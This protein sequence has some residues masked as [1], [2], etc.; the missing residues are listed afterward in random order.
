MPGYQTHTTPW[1]VPGFEVGTSDGGTIDLCLNPDAADAGACPAAYVC[2]GGDLPGGG[3]DGCDGL[4]ACCTELC[5][6][7]DGVP[8]CTN[9]AHECI[10]LFF[11]DPGPPDQQHVGYCALPEVDPCAV[12]G[13]CPPPGIDSS[14]PWCSLA[15]EAHCPDGGLAGFFDGIACEQ[16]CTCQMPCMGPEDC[17]V[18]ATGTATGECVVEPYGPGSPT[19]CLYACDAGQVCPDGMTCSDELGFGA[20][21]VWVS[22]AAPEECM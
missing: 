20:I 17:P 19:T 1:L 18:P 6:L 22:P 15:N 5:D 12:P 8:G 13:N 14:V 4:G 21:C 11:P 9:P 7:E 16:T 10:T 3:G 2:G